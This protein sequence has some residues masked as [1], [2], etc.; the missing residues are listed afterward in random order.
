MTPESFVLSDPLVNG[1][2][3]FRI[4]SIQAAPAAT[5]HRDDADTSEHSEV[6]GNGGLRD[7]HRAD[8]VA[9]RPLSAA[10]QQLDDLSPARLGDRV[11]D[12]GSCCGTGH[13]IGIIF[14]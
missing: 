6:F 12:V 8:E 1:F 14:P 2:E 3:R 13:G 10:G 9:H 11:K 4:K 5:V 7:A